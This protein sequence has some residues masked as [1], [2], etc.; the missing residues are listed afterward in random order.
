[1]KKFNLT[2]ES[3]RKD[4]SFDKD[5]P[6]GIIPLTIKPLLEKRLGIKK[7]L[8]TMDKADSRRNA[9]K[10]WSSALKWEL[11]TSFGFAGFRLAKFGCI[12][13]HEIIQFHGREA[14][15]KAKKIAEDD[16]YFVLA[17]YIDSLTIK[18]DGASSPAD[19]KPLMEKIEKVAL[20]NK[21]LS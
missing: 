16:G 21:V 20:P 5:A 18:K 13:A 8:E 10:A 15:L 6:L 12:E 9:Y 2:P 4:G 17:I 1:M 19:F 3:K 7:A 14:I 11:V